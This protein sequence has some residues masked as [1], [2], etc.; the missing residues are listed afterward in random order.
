MTTETLMGFREFLCIQHDL[1][2]EAAGP[3]NLTEAGT[4]PRVVVSNKLIYTEKLLA[5]LMFWS[6]VERYKD[7]AGE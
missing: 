4:P 1:N 3:A 7:F 2:M 5:D 6:E